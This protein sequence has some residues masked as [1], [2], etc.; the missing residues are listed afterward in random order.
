MLDA[1]RRNAEGI[2]VGT[3]VDAPPCA[4]AQARLP[5]SGCIFN[6][7]AVT[8]ASALKPTINGTEKPIHGEPN[9]LQMIDQ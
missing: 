9:Q 5:V 4:H 8:V 3:V 6:K 2:G 1:R 7:D